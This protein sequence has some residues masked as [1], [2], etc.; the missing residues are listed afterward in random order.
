M[1]L[2]KPDNWCKI[3]YGIGVQPNTENGT[4]TITGNQTIYYQCRAMDGVTVISGTWKWS[5]RVDTDTVTATYDDTGKTL[6]L[7]GVPADVE[8]LID[9]SGTPTSPYDSNAGAIDVP[10]GTTSGTYYIR[11]KSTVGLT[12]IKSITIDPENP[13]VMLDLT[14]TNAT[15]TVHNTRPGDVIWCKGGT[16]S[17]GSDGANAYVN[18]GVEMY[19]G[20][21]DDYTI[22][23]R[24]TYK[25]YMNPD[26]TVANPSNLY[27][28]G[29][30]IDGFTW[31]LTIDSTV[32]T[33][34]TIEPIRLFESPFQGNVVFCNFRAYGRSK[35]NNAW[36]QQYVYFNCGSTAYRCNFEFDFKNM[37]L[38]G[39]V[40][41]ERWLSDCTLVYDI[42]AY[43]PTEAYR[44][45]QIFVSCAALKNSSCDV[46]LRTYN[47]TQNQSS[48][49]SFAV[50]CGNPA[51]QPAMLNSYL[52]ADVVALDGWSTVGASVSTG[53]CIVESVIDVIAIGGTVSNGGGGLSQAFTYV[54]SRM[55]DSKLKARV[56][57]GSYPVSDPAATVR[58]GGFVGDNEIDVEA[59]STGC[60]IGGWEDV[61]QYPNRT[62][63]PR[64]VHLVEYG[65]PTGAALSG[66]PERVNA[67][68]SGTGWY[69]G[70]PN[71]PGAPIEGYETTRG[72]G[73]QWGRYFET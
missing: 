60:T 62:Q 5:R 26:L 40:Y 63:A 13:V 22:R 29:G 53:G 10:D 8:A 44:G 51:G 4:I 45:S 47:G 67:L 34:E 41:A 56:S 9:T 69:S 28:Y 6:T 73:T 23:D 2:A 43:V 27:L 48:T 61:F 16:Y 37:N 65:A 46:R 3:F 71:G 33:T 19:G 39:G 7:T 66:N 18:N 70:T 54:A 12:D 38:S 15:T 55:V 49:A 59:A 1:Y 50:N 57:L 64:V 17:Y 42:E 11:L 31:D 14:W 20:F 36:D 58:T 21:N 24:E 72:T 25:S 30:L 52:T 35:G 68:G 32:V